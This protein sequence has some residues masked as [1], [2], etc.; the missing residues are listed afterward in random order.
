M[1]AGLPGAVRYAWPDKPLAR[2]VLDF[3][4][5]Q[6]GS[7]LQ[8]LVYHTGF[9]RIFTTSKKPRKS[10]EGVQLDN[11]AIGDTVLVATKSGEPYI[12]V[13]VAMWYIAPAPKGATEDAG[14]GDEDDDFLDETRMHILVHKFLR[15]ALDL[16]KIRS[17]RPY[18]KKE[19]YYA[20]NRENA[21]VTLRIPPSSILRRCNISSDATR[22]SSTSL[23]EAQWLAKKPT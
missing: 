13:I 9:E 18:R 23:T 17:E 14:S 7:L 1:R 3:S 8:K 10:L 15:P 20:V 5:H 21:S 19:I 2:R 11:Y 12:A 6:D 22:F 16:P 4:R